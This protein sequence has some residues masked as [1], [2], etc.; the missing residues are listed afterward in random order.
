MPGYARSDQPG[1]ACASATGRGYL[2]TAGNVVSHAM[3][4]RNRAAALRR[5]VSFIARVAA[6]LYVRVYV[7][8]Y[9]S[10]YSSPRLRRSANDIRAH[11]NSREMV[12]PDLH[13]A[14]PPTS[15]GKKKMIG[16][17]FSLSGDT[18]PSTRQGTSQL[19]FTVACWSPARVIHDAC[20]TRCV[21]QDVRA[22]ARARR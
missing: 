17:R 5:S 10:A 8:V 12:P 7:Y 22:R 18:L 16:N 13:R 21:M 11:A 20:I 19:N 9:V 6:T 15:R 4:P 14:P 1:H 3:L 2:F